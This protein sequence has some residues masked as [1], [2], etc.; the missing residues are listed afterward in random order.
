MNAKLTNWRAVEINWWMD[1]SINPLHSR[2][3]C[4]VQQRSIRFWIRAVDRWRSVRYPTITRFSWNLVDRWWL[5]LIQ[6][7]EVADKYGRASLSDCRRKGSMRKRTLRHG[8][9]FEKYSLGCIKSSVRISVSTS[10]SHALEPGS[11]PGRSKNLFPRSI[12]CTVSRQ[13]FRIKV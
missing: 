7:G 2:K 5:L 6:E 3:V 1:Q 11:I 9:L 8:F 13:N 12:F 4:Q 10:A